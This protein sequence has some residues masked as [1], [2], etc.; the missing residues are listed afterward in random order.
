[1]YVYCTVY[2]Y[3]RVL[4]KVHDEK[5]AHCTHNIIQSKNHLRQ[6]PAQTQH[7]CDA[8]IEQIKQIL[9]CAPLG[10]NLR[11]RTG[12]SPPETLAPAPYRIVSINIMEL[13]RP[14]YISVISHSRR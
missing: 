1:M 5:M 7:L 4:V 14:P 9:K 13:V 11:T 2:I 12:A 10:G 3:V 6:L 8:M